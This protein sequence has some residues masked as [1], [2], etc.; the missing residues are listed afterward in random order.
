M[1][2]GS[3]EV[4]AGLDDCL[5]DLL[6]LAADPG[7]ARLHLE[8][9]GGGLRVRARPLRGGPVHQLRL[10]PDPLVPA[11]GRALVEGTGLRPGDELRPE[12]G[13]GL[14]GS[15]LHLVRHREPGAPRFEI[16]SLEGVGGT[17]FSLRALPG[18]RGELASL[19]MG[20][21]EEARLEALLADPGGLILLAVP[22]GEGAGAL[23]HLGTRSP[24]RFPV[25]IQ[26]QEEE[27]PSPPGSLLVRTHPELPLARALE[28]ALRQGPDRVLLGPTLSGEALRGACQA[29]L[30]GVQVLA[31]VP[32]SR[33]ALDLALVARTPGLGELLARGLRAVLLQCCLPLLCPGCRCPAGP[34]ELLEAGLPEECRP[35]RPL[36]RA[37]GCPDCAGSGTVGVLPLFALAEGG[38]ELAA[39]LVAAPGLVEASR[40]TTSGLER[41]RSSLRERV[42]GALRG[43]EVGVEEAGRVLRGLVS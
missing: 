35:G 18:R 12:L 9:V 26:I 27:G 4:P 21:G 39:A 37:R 33:P 43:G 8:P 17:S 23:A 20:Q 5:E 38:P 32:C 19:G 22:P 16:A 1:E 3:T 34:P 14:G 31:A 41:A 10:V 11:L 15:V 36:Y 29:A 25:S 2:T 28:A 30:R 24:G 6:G 7:V 42:L 40:V 13:D